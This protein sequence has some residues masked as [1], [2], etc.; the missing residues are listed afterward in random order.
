[1]RYLYKEEMLLATGSSEMRD[2]DRDT[3]TSPQPTQP[4]PTIN[5]GQ[6]QVAISGPNPISCY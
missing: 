5:K 6:L 2:M 4:F 3:A 1:M